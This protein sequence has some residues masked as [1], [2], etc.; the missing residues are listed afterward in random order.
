MMR[1]GTGGI[2]S[3]ERKSEYGSVFFLHLAVI[4]MIYFSPLIFQW[5]LILLG[6]V[7]YWMQ[8]KFLGGCI[9]TKK[10]FGD[11]HQFNFTAHYLAKIGIRISNQKMSFWQNRI[12]P[13]V[14]IVNVI[15]WQIVLKHKPF[16]EI[17]FNF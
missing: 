17:R 1:S 2:M 7:L 8:I 11:A 9:L 14:I 4:L 15:Y 6:L 5:Q 10:Q 12:L 16:M 13:W 3:E